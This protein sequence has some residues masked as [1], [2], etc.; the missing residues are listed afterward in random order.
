MLRK[1]TATRGSASSCRK[2]FRTP[3]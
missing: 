1:M 2:I 3:V